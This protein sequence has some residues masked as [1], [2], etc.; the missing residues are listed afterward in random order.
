MPL[1]PKKNLIFSCNNRRLDNL[2]HNLQHSK[3]FFKKIYSRGKPCKYYT[4]RVLYISFYGLR[5]PIG[6]TCTPSVRRVANLPPV[7]IINKSGS[8]IGFCFS[9]RLCS[10][11]SFFSCNKCFAP[12]SAR[13]NFFLQ[14]KRKLQS[15]NNLRFKLRRERLQNLR[16]HRKS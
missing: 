16:N 12:S 11:I 8:R 10:I 13:E 1:P 3:T 7:R 6:T 2:R 15:S 14:K 9:V 4:S 5:Q